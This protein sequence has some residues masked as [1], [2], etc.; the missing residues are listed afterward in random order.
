MI[1]YFVILSGAKDPGLLA[2][3]PTPRI[4]R[5]AQ[6]DAPGWGPANSVSSAVNHQ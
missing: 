3:R 1:H 6:D 5:S 2:R 4:L